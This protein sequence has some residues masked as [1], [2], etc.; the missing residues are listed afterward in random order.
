MLESVD[1]LF[2]A[3]SIFSASRFD[4]QAGWDAAIARRDCRGIRGY[5]DDVFLSTLGGKITH[6]LSFLYCYASSTVNQAGV[7]VVAVTV[8]VPADES[9]RSSEKVCEPDVATK[10]GVCRKEVMPFVE[11][12]C[13]LPICIELLYASMT[14]TPAVDERFI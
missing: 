10:G 8:A 2:D 3:G 14:A 11:L 7:V 12:F 4:F 9:H 13:A 1:V 6:L 5:N